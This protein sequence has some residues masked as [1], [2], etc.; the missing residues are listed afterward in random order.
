MDEYNIELK[1][2]A[3]EE[4][5]LHDFISIKFKR[6]QNSSRVVDIGLVATLPRKKVVT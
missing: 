1:K 6:R 5:L 2:T 3:S 4:H